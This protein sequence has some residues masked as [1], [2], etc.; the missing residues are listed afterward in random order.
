[1]NPFGNR[2]VNLKGRRLTVAELNFL[3]NLVVSKVKTIAQVAKYYNLPESNIGRYSKKV[4][5]SRPFFSSG[6]RPSQLDEISHA[7]LKEFSTGIRND[8][9]HQKLRE[10]IQENY[11]A[12]QQRRHLDVEELFQPK[13]VPS[14]TFLRHVALYS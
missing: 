4:K 14:R 2:K 10:L 6:G 1:M 9:F 11:I 13:P 7:I 3:G 12:T 5:D 8:D